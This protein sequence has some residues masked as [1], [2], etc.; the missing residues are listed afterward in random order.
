MERDLFDSYSCCIP[1]CLKNLLLDARRSQVNDMLDLHDKGETF[2][3]RVKSCSTFVVILFNALLTTGMDIASLLANAFFIYN[4]YLVSLMPAN[5]QKT[6]YKIVMVT[7]TA[8][9]ISS[10][11]IYYSNVLRLK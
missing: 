8:A 1:S 2:R 10:Y 4:V 11:F 3:L 5:I 6:E 7:C 9:I